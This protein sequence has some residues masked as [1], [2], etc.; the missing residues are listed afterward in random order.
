M[1]AHEFARDARHTFH[2]WA[3]RPWQTAYAILALA[4]GIGANMGVFSIANA[5][6][7]RSLPFHQTE[8]LASFELF[9]PPHD[10]PKRFHEWRRQT[11]FLDDAALW[12]TGDGNLGGAGEK[13]GECIGEISARHSAPICTVFG[14][15]LRP[16]LTLQ[17]EA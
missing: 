2:L 4:I 15:L 1:N 13:R 5:L 14:R 3:V 16:L 6:L 9:F 7:L 11:A 8:S 12:E 17:A 10:S